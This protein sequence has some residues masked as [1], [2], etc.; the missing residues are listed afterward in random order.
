ML[1]AWDG[2]GTEGST[3]S[4]DW[5]RRRQGKTLSSVSVTTWALMPSPPCR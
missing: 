2:G 5:G 3:P 4:D 1:G